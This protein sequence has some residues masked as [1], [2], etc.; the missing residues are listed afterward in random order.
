MPP[1]FPRSERSRWWR[2]NSPWHASQGSTPHEWGAMSRQFLRRVLFFLIGWVIFMVILITTLAFL[3]SRI[4]ESVQLPQEVLIIGRP[5][6]LLIGLILIIGVFRSARYMRRSTFPLGNLMEAVGRVADGDYKV[7]LEENGP[8][9]MRNMA[10]AFNSMAEK[11]QNNDEQRRRLLADVTHELRTP[12]T[13]I[14]GNLEGMIDG[15][16]PS[17]PAHIQTV[18]DETRLMSHIVDDLRTLSL[19]ESGA[20]KLEKERTALDQVIT[21]VV[22]S[23]EGSAAK[24]AINLVSNF[25]PDL[26]EVD[27]DVTRI[28]EVLENLVSNALRYTPQG[29]SVNLRAWRGEDGR[30]LAVSVTDTGKGISPDDL[31]HIFDR[32]YKTADSRGT[33]LGLAIARSLVEAH[34]GEIHAERAP[35]QGTRI[36]FTIPLPPQSQ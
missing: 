20:L 26:P 9:E 32:F 5:L 10:R 18:L 36:W 22:R 17:D 24:A 31:E 34:G 28:R 29:G 4:L 13:V 14:Q 21:E 8:P 7:R 11:L 15:I 30:T 35:S 6:G 2:E 23:F 16:Y 12:I 25:V 33:G 19:S 3:I 1:H 27:I